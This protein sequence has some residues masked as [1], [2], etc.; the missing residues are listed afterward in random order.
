M[1]DSSN[2]NW[3]PKSITILPENP[4]IMMETKENEHENHEGFYFND[5][6]QIYMIKSMFIIWIAL[7]FSLFNLMLGPRQQNLE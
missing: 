7:I 1:Y 5:Y 6:S 4:P 2:S 3:A